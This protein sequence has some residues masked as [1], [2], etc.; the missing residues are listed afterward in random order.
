MDN[1]LAPDGP[2][3]GATR[4]SEW[5]EENGERVG[6]RYASEVE[7]HFVTARG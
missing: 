6:R 1:L 4:L 5:L 2:S 3:V 7:R